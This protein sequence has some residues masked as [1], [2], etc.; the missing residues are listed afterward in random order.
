MG[1][2][3]RGERERGGGGAERSRDR[4]EK[5]REK[6]EGIGRREVRNGERL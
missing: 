5:G 2:E 4:E 1:R 6:D 3:W